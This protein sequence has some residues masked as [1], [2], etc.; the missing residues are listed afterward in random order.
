MMG[1][2]SVA[3]TGQG[4]GPTKPIRSAIANRTGMLTDIVDRNDI[5]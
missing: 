1:A 4:C 2:I 5:N 3:P